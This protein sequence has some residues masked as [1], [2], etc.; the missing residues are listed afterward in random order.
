MIRIGTTFVVVLLLASAAC[1]PVSPRAGDSSF[2]FREGRREEAI[3]GG[4]LDT[5][6]NNVVAILI[7]AGQGGICTGS[8]IAPNLVLT[9]RH[10]VA[11]LSQ[12]S[13]D[14][15]SA[16]PFGAT[17]PVGSFRITNSPSAAAAVYGGAS[18]WPTVNNTTWF[19]GAAIS[20]PPTPG[21]T[22]CGGDL[23]LIR[24]SANIDNV[25]PLIPRVDS[26]LGTNELYRAVG[27]GVTSPNGQRAGTR[28]SV[29]GMTVFCAGNCAEAS[30]SDP[31]EWVGG[32]QAAKGACQGDSGGPAIDS[33]GRVTGAVSRGG[34]SACNVAVYSGVF[35]HAQWIKDET[36]LAAM[37]GGFTAP[38]WASG[39]S[40]TVNPCGPIDGGV[41]VD[42][43][44]GAGG[45]GGTSVTCVTGEYCAALASNGQSACVT[46]SNGI[47]AGSPSCSGTMACPSEY[48]CWG[49]G[50]ANGIC[51]RDCTDG[52]PPTGNTGGGG[53]G[54]GSVGTCPS[55][56]W[57]IDAS[58]SGEYACVTTMNSVPP[59][60][61]DC[62]TT[63]M[64]ESGYSCWGI[65]QTRAV[66]LADCSTT[67]DA[68][69]E[70]DAG[71]ELGYLPFEKRSAHLFFQLVARRYEKGSML[72]TT[73]QLVSQ[74]GGVF[75]DDVLAAAILDRLLHHSHTL[76]IQG[77]SYRLRQKRKAG[78]LAR[79][80]ER[81]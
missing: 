15:C 35:G 13:L 70:V 52:V 12:A 30:I 25:C 72:I 75:G 23:A 39:G 31:Y 8:L 42:P 21:N 20:F 67:P 27:Y 5:T 55:G 26:Q 11:A 19:T 2:V 16:Q 58:G 54:S 66:C 71:T 60:A 63:R 24:L 50:G 78:L 77:E 69:T 65:S 9:A 32:A 45:G 53:G 81:T 34:E 29:S 46:T 38:A 37:A 7:G 51:L 56:Q 47:P 3:Q 79:G 64:C 1:E 18:Q 62:T 14:D 57:C 73:N 33:I 40:T 76:V 61:A 10:C 48:S 28:Y 74:W 41:N 59:D 43:D 6:S 17:F 44:G 49:N 22:I 80:P 36:L 4:T 68:G